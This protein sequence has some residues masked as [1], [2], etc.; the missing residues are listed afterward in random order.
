MSK[1]K[2]HLIVVEQAP[3]ESDPQGYYLSAC[4]RDYFEEWTENKSVVTCKQCI[5]ILAQEQDDEV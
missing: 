3:N 2:I 4:G 1:L 5:K